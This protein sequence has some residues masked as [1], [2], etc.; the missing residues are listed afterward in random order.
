MGDVSLVLVFLMLCHLLPS[1]I[2]VC[3]VSNFVSHQEYCGPF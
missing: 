2:Q 3:V 1:V